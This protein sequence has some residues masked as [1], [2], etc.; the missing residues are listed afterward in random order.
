MKDFI[1]YTI[2]F[3]LGALLIF[4]FC[5]KDQEKP[6]DNSREKELVG[7]IEQLELDNTI[8]KAKNDSLETLKQR[9]RTQIVY[10]TAQIDS[11]ILKDS[12]NSLVEYRRSLQDNNYL[13][14]G[15]LYLSYREIGLGAILMA[16]LPKLELE[17]KY[18]EEQNLNKD[19]VISNQE[20][21]ID[22]YKEVGKIKDESINYWQKLYK[23]ES[24]WY[25][26]NWIWLTLGVVV[27]GGIAIAVK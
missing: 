5:S 1:L 10:R 3:L 6:P 20:Y 16:K 19:V 4:K 13:P 18:C 27:T 9:T 24:A 23:K 2:I 7:K 22:G 8:L 26:E 21:I 25:N 14:D 11:A 17:L 15:T 12:S